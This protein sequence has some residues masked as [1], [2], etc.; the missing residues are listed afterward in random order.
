M[1]NL[2]CAPRLGLLL[3]LSLA[4]LPWLR[5]ASKFQPAR[6]PSSADS[7][8]L[9]SLLRSDPKLAPVIKRAAAYEVQIIYT[10]INRDAQNRP[11][12]VQHNFRL[13]E[14]QYFNPASL[15]KL[16]VAA[17]ALE[18]LNQLHQP[19]LTRNSPLSIGT[20]F[21][22]QTRCPTSPPL[23]PTNSTPSAIM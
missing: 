15:V 10:Q 20:A 17:L 4:L 19:G 2:F 13:N 11:H 9:D 7:P 14:R 3:L 23:I 18:K 6:L 12:F 1:T 8:L 16:P 22:C 21:R 5:A